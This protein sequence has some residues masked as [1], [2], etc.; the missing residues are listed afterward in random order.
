MLLQLR[1][2]WNPV[3]SYKDRWR[4]AGYFDAIMKGAFVPNILKI[5]PVLLASSS[6]RR[7]SAC[8]TYYPW[9]DFHYIR[10]HRF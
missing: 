7:D 6:Y 1:Q 10:V 2:E 4:H 5:A 8:L 3:L 9:W